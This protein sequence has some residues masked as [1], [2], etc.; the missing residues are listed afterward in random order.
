MK[1][2][3]TYLLYGFT[4]LV[5]VL[6]AYNFY[7][8]TKRAI[9][10]KTIKSLNTCTIKMY[11]EKFDLN[12][13]FGYLWGIKEPKK[14]SVAIVK[15]IHKDM[16]ATILSVTKEK[17][18]ICIAKNCY[19][20]LGIYYK[21]GIPYISFYSKKFKKGLQDFSL[22]QTLDKTLYI[23]EIKHNRLFIADTNSSREWQFQLFDVNATK[24]K[25]KENNETTL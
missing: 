10:D 8:Q 4:V 17:G 14:E 23:K 7:G 18:K 1:N 24:Y 3:F 5:V 9:A 20:L 2:K 15:V 12:Q 13:T 6:L 11:K 16:N 19:R 25:P 22:H 21:A